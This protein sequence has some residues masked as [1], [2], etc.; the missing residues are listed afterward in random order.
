MALVYCKALEKAMQACSKVINSEAPIAFPYTAW[1][2]TGKASGATLPPR[3]LSFLRQS[4]NR[5]AA[6]YCQL[7]SDCLRSALR[8][9]VVQPRVLL[10]FGLGATE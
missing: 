1:F 7:F 2:G 4:D 6:C 8:P 5:V 9:N 3:D 10:R